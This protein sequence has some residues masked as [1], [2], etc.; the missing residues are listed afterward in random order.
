MVSRF[1]IFVLAHAAFVG[2]AIAIGLLDNQPGQI[3]AAALR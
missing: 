2:S 3:L 1:L